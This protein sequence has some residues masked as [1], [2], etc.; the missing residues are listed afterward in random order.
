MQGLKAICTVLV[1][2][3]RLFLF[4]A[5]RLDFCPFTPPC[6]PS[7]RQEEPVFAGSQ[8]PGP[9]RP[10]GS[11]AA[12]RGSG[13][14]PQAPAQQ[15]AAPAKP[16]QVQR[17]SSHKHLP[18]KRAQSAPCSCT[19]RTCTPGNKVTH[20]LRTCRQPL[21]P[22][23]VLAW[24]LHGSAHSW[25][26]CARSQFLRQV[27]YL[28]NG[29]HMSCRYRSCVAVTCWSSTQIADFTPEKEAAQGRD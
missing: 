16:A 14:R 6:F 27:S 26:G 3:Q 23:A 24:H 7:Q 10:R 4:E 17:C 28:R 22:Q 8:S 21:M 5:N 13:V 29:Y 11:Q 25:Q 1:S 2:R 12:A 20:A 15:S 18:L 9:A 19:P